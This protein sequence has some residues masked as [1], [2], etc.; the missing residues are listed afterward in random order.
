M[1][2]QEPSAVILASAVIN[3]NTDIGKYIASQIQ[4]EGRDPSDVGAVLSFFQ[5]HAVRTERDKY[6]LIISVV[7]LVGWLAV[8]SRVPSIKH[9]G[10]ISIPA[11]LVLAFG[12]RYYAQMTKNDEV[13]AAMEVLLADRVIA[14]GV[15]QAA[16]PPYT[17]ATLPL[18]TSPAF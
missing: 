7:V 15:A 1:N 3:Q 9:P 10:L 14:Q 18:N 13:K 4:A 2:H 11:L 6:L 17:Q 8:R 5:D 12:W 16:P